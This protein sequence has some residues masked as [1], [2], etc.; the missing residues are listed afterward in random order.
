VA[1]LAVLTNL[2]LTTPTIQRPFITQ[3][4]VSTLFF[5]N[6]AGGIVLFA[7]AYLSAPL[8]GL[9]FH[10]KRVTHVSVFL[11]SLI[12]MGAATAQFNAVLA[13]NMRWFT[14]QAIDLAGRLMGA[15]VGILLAWKTDWG[16]Y[17]LL[18]QAITTAGLVLVLTWAACP[19]GPSLHFDLRSV[20]SELRMGLDLLTFNLVN[21][22]HRQADNIIIGYRWGP[23]E[24][25]YYSRAYNIMQQAGSGIST[26]IS[27]AMIP[28][29]SRV[30]GNAERWRKIFLDSA[31]LTAAACG[32]LFAILW[33]V[34]RPLVDILLG[35]R[36]HEVVPMFGYLLIAGLSTSVCSPFTWG[37]VT[38]GRTRELL[39][40]ILFAAP[41]LVVAFWIG[42]SFG[43]VGV[44]IAYA[45]TIWVINFLYVA[46]ALKG[47]PVTFLEGVSI[48]AVVYCGFAMVAL[49]NLLID[50]YVTSAGTIIDFLI[51]GTLASVL[52]VLVIVLASLIVPP[53]TGIQS[54]LSMAQSK[55][56]QH[57]SRCGRD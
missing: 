52:Y 32:A 20:H 47:T 6:L 11:A 10:D 25:G 56:S 9:I 48:K 16:V 51:R 31:S 26:P 28:A 21:F 39:Y 57:A 54:L 33:A 42:A 5:I 49:G 4:Q 2:G 17:A 53:F 38:F 12:P 29:L 3:E 40:W 55:F 36:W 19:W 50:R 30:C 41:V 37:F 8:F 7:L 46:L 24:L 13:R 44:A 27:N 43:G 14:I 23:V 45:V 1:L 34:R 22:L 15:M 18:A 35:S